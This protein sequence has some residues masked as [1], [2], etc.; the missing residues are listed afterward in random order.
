MFEENSHTETGAN[1]IAAFQKNGLQVE[2]NLVVL[3]KF[4]D[5]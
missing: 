2:S 3:I 1:A 4:F 5:V